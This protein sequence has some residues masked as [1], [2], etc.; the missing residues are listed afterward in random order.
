ML[1]KANDTA[2][3]QTVQKPALRLINRQSL[4]LAQRIARCAVA[5]K[6]AFHWSLAQNLISQSYKLIY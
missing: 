6:N 1:L 2:R 4:Q 5:E 3:L